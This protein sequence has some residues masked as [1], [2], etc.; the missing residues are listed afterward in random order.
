MAVTFGRTVHALC[1]V[2]ALLT[3]GIL[4]LGELAD[5]PEESFTAE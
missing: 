4:R 3:N 5:E 2:H 1:S